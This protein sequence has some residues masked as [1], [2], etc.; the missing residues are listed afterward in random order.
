MHGSSV[1]TCIYPPGCLHEHK[2]R[3]TPEQLRSLMNLGGLQEVS[4][5]I[6]TEV[7]TLQFHNQPTYI[8]VKMYLAIWK[9]LPQLICYS[10][11]L[12]TLFRL[13]HTSI[14]PFFL[15]GSLL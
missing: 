9:W 14:S 2:T 11:N 5:C 10:A 3:S 4:N 6:S 7:N 13:L 1:Y 8:G 12:F 15:F